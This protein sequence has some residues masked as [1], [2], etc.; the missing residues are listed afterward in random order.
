[1]CH[2]AGSR[3]RVDPADWTC[4]QRTEKPVYL[5]LPGYKNHRGQCPGQRLLWD[6]AMLAASLGHQGGAGEQN[7]REE[8]RGSP[9]DS[10]MN[11]H[12]AQ[13][14]TLESGYIPQDRI[15]CLLHW[16]F[17]NENH[18]TTSYFPT[19]GFSNVECWIGYTDFLPLPE[20]KDQSLGVCVR[21]EKW[22]AVPV[23][24][25]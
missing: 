25:T 17:A 13:N 23:W 3:C 15:I 7:K 21:E 20:T 19:I 22:L 6:P 11:G 5:F 16:L 1:M 2:P 12:W 4:W 8:R 14:R 24:A 10:E 18:L 9:L